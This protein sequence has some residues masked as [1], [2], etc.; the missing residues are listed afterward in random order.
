V[1]SGACNTAPV[2]IGVLG[3]TGPAGRGLAAR[4]ASVG[5]EVRAGSRERSRA[6]DAVAELRA[7]WGDRVE[8]LE[9]GTNAEAAKANDLVI[10]ATTWEGAVAT[11][12]E[13]ADDLASKPVIV[14]ANGLERVGREFRPVLPPEGSI[15]RAAQ[16]AAP[17]ARVVAAFQHV[18][19]A[20]FA[21]L[22]EPLESDVLVCADDDDARTLVLDLVASIPNLRAFDAG[23]LENAVGN[24]AFGAVLLTCNLRHKGKGTLRLLGLDGYIRT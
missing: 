13:H 6:D 16:A 11:A 7:Q 18:P 24:E 23:S 1:D 9:P 15:A 5:H 12:A 20:A 2:E 22:D 14:M 19:A 3:A 10:I 21:A 4:L 8:R 17:D